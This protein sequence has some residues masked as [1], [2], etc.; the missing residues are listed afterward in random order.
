[1]VE[2]DDCR[3]GDHVRFRLLLLLVD[4]GSTANFQRSDFMSR[5]HDAM[6]RAG[7]APEM[8]LPAAAYVPPRENGMRTNGVSRAD[9]PPA[10]APVATPATT[11]NLPSLLGL[12]EEHPFNPAPE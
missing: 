1:M 5:V 12:M 10:V 3:R 4:L 11:L 9:I 2:R 7:Q 6:L 8:D